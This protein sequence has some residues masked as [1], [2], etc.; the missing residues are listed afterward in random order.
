MALDALTVAVTGV[1]GTFGT[2][3][4]PLLEADERVGRVVGVSRRPPDHGDP[5]VE[6]RSGD[7]RDLPSLVESFVGADVVVH[8]AFLI[9]GNAAPATLRETNV[10]GT[11]NAFRAAVA[12]GARRFVLASSLAAYGFGPDLPI[13]IPEQHPVRPGDRFFYAAEKAE[14]EQALAAEA[15]EHPEIEVYVLRPCGVVGPNALGGK[16]LAPGRF[17]PAARRLAERV[18]RARLPLPLPVPVPALRL[19]LVHHDDVGE[20]LHRA[21]VADGPPGT[22]NIAGDGVVTLVDLVR[23]FGAAP[24]PLPEAVAQVPARI[25]TA[26]PLPPPLQWIEAGTHPLIMDTTRART[27]LGWRPRY[28]GLDAWRDTLRP[29]SGPRRP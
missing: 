26:L 1:T 29:A 3:L 25:L 10:V 12:V 19:Q 23:E 11:L 20:A 4:V 28:S 13:G 8:L 5:D 9:V 27:R 24:I 15:A 17:A 18:L 14:T 7:V 16:D 21:V 6:F 2:S 22:Y